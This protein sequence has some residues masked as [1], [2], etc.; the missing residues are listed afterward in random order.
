MKNLAPRRHPVAL[1][2][3]M[4]MLALAFAL[5]GSQPAHT[6][7]NGRPGL[8]NAE[9][10]LAK[11]GAIHT[12]GWAPPSPALGPPVEPAGSAV[13]PSHVWAPSPSTC[14]TDPRAPPLA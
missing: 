9:C 7:E 4:A 6:H 5:E 12:D 14:F 11:V 8:Y 13:V 2:L 1:V 3:L 10:P